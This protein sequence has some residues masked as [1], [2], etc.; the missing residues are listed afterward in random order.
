MDSNALIILAVTGTLSFVV[1]NLLRRAWRKRRNQKAQQ[2]LRDMQTLAKERQLQAP[3][4][5][6]KAKRRRQQRERG[7][8]PR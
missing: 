6:N 3:P 4:A 7:Q 5:L 1:G 8:S 2:L